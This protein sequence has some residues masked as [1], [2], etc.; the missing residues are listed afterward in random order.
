MP[1]NQQDIKPKNLK[2][3][4]FLVRKMA[5][6][7]MLPEEWIDKVIGH[8]KKGINE[9]LKSHHQVEISG[10]GKFVLSQVKLK[11]KIIGLEKALAINHQRV[12]DN[13][14]NEEAKGKIEIF[15]KEIQYHKSKLK[16]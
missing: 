10:F 4:D 15:E 12:L 2:L 5:V 1:D 6:K 9:A 8:E 3:H 7:M 14:A 16:S 13:P 11:K